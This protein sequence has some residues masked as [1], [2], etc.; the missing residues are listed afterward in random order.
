M[1]V[2]I[3][4]FVLINFLILCGMAER[5]KKIEKKIDDIYKI[6]LDGEKVSNWVNKVTEDITNIW[7]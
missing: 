7:S 1:L 4:I 5:I 3:L 6:F 2:F